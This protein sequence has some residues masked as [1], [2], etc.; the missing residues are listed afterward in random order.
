VTDFT[1]FTLVRLA[2]GRSGHLALP[3][4]PF[5]QKFR[6]HIFAYIQTADIEARFIEIMRTVITHF[7]N[8]EYL[9]PWWLSH[10]LRLFDYGILIDHGS[11]DNSADICRAIAPN[12]KLVRS[13]LTHF[14]AFMTDWEAMGYEQE[15]PGWKIILN[16]T[17]FLLPTMDLK[18]LELALTRAGRT[19]FCA[20]GVFFVDC[21]PTVMPSYDLPL[22]V[23]K[24]HGFDDNDITDSLKRKKLNLLP[25]GSTRNRFYHCNPLGM[26]KMGRH[27]SYHP[28]SSYRLTDVF[29]GWFGYSPW[30]EKTI[31]R[32]IQIGAKLPSINQLMNTGTHHQRGRE[33]LEKEYLNLK[34]AAID[35]KEVPYISTAI[36][37]CTNDS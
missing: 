32:K 36:Q 34:S 35:L 30:N 12:W 23:Q 27:G 6:W 8:E 16:V 26:Y 31:K 7:Y 33:E 2:G 14:E 18:R 20:S 37:A 21:E 25:E 3:L 19:G 11:T 1:N 9:L 28:D 15:V 5:K 4:N 10:H 17:E 22:P 29:I 24:H 13:K